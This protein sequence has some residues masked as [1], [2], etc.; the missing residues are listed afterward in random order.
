[1]VKITLLGNDFV[2]NFL[3]K[4]KNT[5][6]EIKNGEYQDM[7]FHSIVLDN[8]SIIL[9]GDDSL[10]LYDNVAAVYIKAIGVLN[11]LADIL[12]DD[13]IYIAKMEAIPEGKERE[14]LTKLIR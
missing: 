7:H 9:E 11:K 2:L 6:I 10:L 1:M 13:S 4:G 3:T 14:M 12:N 5:R 8:N